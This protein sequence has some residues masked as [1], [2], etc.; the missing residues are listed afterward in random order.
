MKIMLMTPLPPV[1][2]FGQIG[3]S[4][5]VLLGGYALGCLLCEVYQTG[6][7]QP[8]LL[9]VVPAMIGTLIATNFDLFLDVKKRADLFEYDG[10]DGN[11]E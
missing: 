7:G 9:Y 5:E 10:S 3:K 8:A 1:A 6:S 2:K 11:N 4:M